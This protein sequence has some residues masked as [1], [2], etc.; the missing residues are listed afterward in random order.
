LIRSASV[1]G[2]QRAKGGEQEDCFIPY[3]RN[4]LKGGLKMQNRRVLG[5]LM[6]L[7]ILIMA[8]IMPTA[9]S[10]REAAQEWELLNPAGV[11]SIKPIEM[12]PRIASLEGKTVGLKWNAKPN[13]NLFLDRVAELLTKQVRGVRIVKFYEVEPTTVPQSNG[14]AVAKAKAQIIAKYKPDIVIGSQCD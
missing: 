3:S 1:S 4:E 11:I 8:F 10:A 7:C 2:K 9:I 12:A 5:I 6:A 14:A 13:G